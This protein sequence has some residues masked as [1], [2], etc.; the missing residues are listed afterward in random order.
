MPKYLDHHASMPNLPQE[1]VAELKKKLESKQPDQFGVT[2]INMFVGKDQTWC[3]VEAPNSD[4]IHKA[5]EAMGVKL[6]AGEVIEV[7]NLV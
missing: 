6:G 2:G 7:Q 3:Y 4:A 5:H 1:A